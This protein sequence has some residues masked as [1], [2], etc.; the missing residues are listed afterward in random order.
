VTAR[1]GRAARVVIAAGAALAI[2]A[3]AGCEVQGPLAFRR[4]EPSV[5]ALATSWFGNTFGGAAQHWMPRV[6]SGLGVTPDGTVVVMGED[7]SPGGYSDTA[8]LRGGDMVGRLADSSGS[9]VTAAGD[10]SY[11]YAAFNQD[12]ATGGA[13]GDYPPAGTTWHGVR[14]YTPAGVPAPFAGGRGPDGSLLLVSATDRVTGLA[15]SGGA[16]YV[17]HA[18]AG[19]T[20]D[21]YDAAALTRTRTFP[22]AGASALTVDRAGT[23]WAIAGDPAAVVHLTSAGAALPEQLAELQRPTALG[24]DVGGRLLVADDGPRQQVVVYGDLQTTPRLVQTYGAEGGLTASHGGDIRPERFM[25]LTAV[26]GD[27]SGNVYVGMA[28]AGRSAGRLVALA[29]DGHPLWQAMSLV[30]FD[31]PAVDPASDGLDVYT[32]NAR[33]RMDYGQ[34]AGAEAQWAGWTLDRSIF[35]DDPRDW[36]GDSAA[37]AI[38]SVGGVKLLADAASFSSIRI[39]R[40]SPGLERLTPAVVIGQ[41]DAPGLPATSPARQAKAWMWRDANGDGLPQASEYEGF[42]AD[43]SWGGWV[44][45]HG[46][47]WRATEAKGI[48]RFAAEGVDG[49][50]VPIYLVASRR[51][52]AMPAP[53]VRIQ[54]IA[55]LAAGDVTYLSGYTDA[56]NPYGTEA[57][58][59]IGTDLVRYDGWDGARTIRWRLSLLLDNMISHRACGFAVAGS[60]LFVTYANDDAI[61]VHDADTGAGIG[62]FLPGPNISSW[63]ATSRS[64]VPLSA[65][66]RKNGEILLF[67]ADAPHSKV[68]MFRVPPDWHE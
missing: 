53:F 13:S 5:M 64:L 19:G 50:G 17:A 57:W 2:G 59:S 65:F 28:M 40:F 52:Q 18:T 56:A 23:L 61:Y 30:S 1:R 20:V 22:L 33:F 12:P 46:E 58:T 4:P 35:P 68:T 32:R 11:V 54:Q 25:G 47:I 10:G 21:V 15:L 42:D 62:K 41:H 39:H 66:A 6:I 36:A 49:P 63:L 44:D 37:V 16:L 14:R 45:E 3:S 26:A 60:R 55:H 51:H 38:V 24:L 7:L 43:T 8:L 29:P 34:P 31:T 9:G 48:D 67:A 27:R